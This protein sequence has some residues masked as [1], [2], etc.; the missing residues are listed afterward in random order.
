MIKSPKKKYELNI[1][2]EVEDKDL[3]NLDISGEKEMSKFE[4]MPAP[5]NLPEEEKKG[6]QNHED[7][8]A[9][10]TLKGMEK[11]VQG[12][13]LRSHKELNMT[14]EEE[15][16][17]EEYL[18]PSKT[19]GRIGPD[20]FKVLKVLGKGSFGDVYLVERKDVDREG[21]CPLT[22]KK[23]AMKILPKNKVIKQNLI[24]YAMTEKRVM[25]MINHPF[26]IKLN[27][28]FQ[29]PDKLY[30]VLDYCPGG[31]LSEYLNIER[32]FSEKKA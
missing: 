12:L 10:M 24:R 5:K 9:Q 4:T 1:E 20:H 27:Y 32:S 2:R 17:F 13:S 3:V 26:I 16:K 23:F 28:A 11:E 6:E 7:K 15:K 19:D 31:D 29:T 21:D 22:G 8:L 14:A 18:S 25:S 30:M